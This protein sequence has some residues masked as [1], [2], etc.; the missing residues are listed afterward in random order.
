MNSHVRQ[1]LSAGSSESIYSGFLILDS[2]GRPKNKEKETRF[3]SW[4]RTSWYLKLFLILNSLFVCQSVWV[5]IRFVELFIL[6]QV[7]FIQPFQ[8]LNMIRS[9][10]IHIVISLP[11]SLPHCSSIPLSSPFFPF[12]FFFSLLNPPLNPL[13]LF[14]FL[15]PPFL[16]PTNQSSHLEKKEAGK[17]SWK[18]GWGWVPER[19]KIEDGL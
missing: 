14:F 2:L 17:Y 15:L 9:F 8:Y 10:N 12:P 6:S 16:I 5:N 19:W 11:P 1:P 18:S 13:P 4:G 7:V 3:N